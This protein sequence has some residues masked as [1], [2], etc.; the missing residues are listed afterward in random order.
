MS[1]VTP[2]IKSGFMVALNAMLDPSGDHDAVQ[3]SRLIDPAMLV[4][5]EADAWIES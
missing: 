4:E 5:I 1:D 3:I 2:W